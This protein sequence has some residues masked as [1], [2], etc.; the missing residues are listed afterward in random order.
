MWRMEGEP[1]A[2][3]HSFTD[4]T[5]L[6]QQGA[7]S[8]MAHTGITTGTTPTTYSP[9]DPVSRG[10]LAT[11]FHRYAGE[12][13]VTVDSSSPLCGG[14]ENDEF[15][16]GGADL[17]GGDTS[18]WTVLNGHLADVVNIDRTVAGHLLVVPTESFHNGWFE[19]SNGVFVHQPVQGDFA[20]AIRIRVVSA[21]DPASGDAP[22]ASF[23]S[24]G[25][26]V[27][28]STDGD[29]WVMYNMGHPA[30]GF[31]YGREVKTTVDASSAL[32][33]Y[34]QPRRRT[35]CWSVESEPSST[36]ST[37][38]P[39]VPNGPKRFFTTTD[40][41]SEPKSRSASS[42]T[43]GRVVRGPGSK[44][45]P[46]TSARRR[47]WPPARPRSHRSDQRDPRLA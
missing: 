26:L 33:L 29:D 34:P 4:V 7:V 46:S 12:P 22:G 11:F 35:G 1:A 32:N 9:D 27:R 15:S 16:G 41:T 23:N 18:P 45:M 40:P 13:P 42:P 25:F 20:A 17:L 3:P 28:D 38:R 39:R 10:Q 8:W 2:P 44:S 37:V 47:H 5:A 24:G 30:S 19:S 36:T 31:G 14:A 6:W 21:A 43:R